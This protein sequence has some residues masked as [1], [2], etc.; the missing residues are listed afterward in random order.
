[1]SKARGSVS[2]FLSLIL[3][4]CLLFGGLLCDLARMSAAKRAAEGAADLAL[5]AVMS[6][7]DRILFER[8][9]LFAAPGVGFS[10]SEKGAD[11][12]DKTVSPEGIFDTGD[13]YARGIINRLLGSVTEAVNR[14]AGLIELE[15]TGYSV[16]AVPESCLGNPE[17]LERQIIDYMKYRGPLAAAATLSEKLG[18]VK[19]A[20]KSGKAASSKLK[21]ENK[22]SELQ[23]ASDAICASLDLYWGLLEISCFSPDS[24]G[25]EEKCSRAVSA[26]RS[27][28]EKAEI[29]GTASYVCGEIRRFLE[30]SGTDAA[31]DTNFFPAH[32][33]GL[34]K[35][36]EWKYLCGNYDF[37]SSTN[38]ASEY[39]IALT[40][41]GDNL[42]A[43][44]EAAAAVLNAE[45][46]ENTP[47]A[48]YAGRV[49]DSLYSI[50]LKAD[51][52]EGILLSSADSDLSEASRLFSEL[53]K[54]ADALSSLAGEIVASAQQFISVA[55]ELMP[56]LETWKADVEELSEG[57]IKTA[58][59]TQIKEQTLRIDADGARRL[60][61]VASGWKDAFDSASNTISAYSVYGVAVCGAST[62]DAE[63]MAKA[64]VRVFSSGAARISEAPETPDVPSRDE[65]LKR[66]TETAAF[67]SELYAGRSDAAL[68]SATDGLVGEIKNMLSD[69]TQTGAESGSDAPERIS[70]AGGECFRLINLYAG[71]AGILSDA[72]LPSASMDG[73]EEGIC[74]SAGS[75]A[76][77]SGT[78]LSSILSFLENAGEDA[79]VCGYLCGVFSCSGDER[80]DV[81]KITCTDRSGSVFFG[82]EIEY[83]IFGMDRADDNLALA[84]ASV[85]GIR[86]ALNLIYALTDPALGESSLA[87]ATAIAG[88]SGFGIP[89]VQ[90]LILVALA[91]AESV[92]DLVRL[93]KGNSVAVWKSGE[94]WKCSI[95][96]IIGS[97]A[98]AADGNGSDSGTVC[99]SFRDYM[100]ILLAAAYPLGKN[101]VLSRC[102]KLI[103][104]NMSALEPGFVITSAGT[105]FILDAEA[106]L[107]GTL[108]PL[109]SSEWNICISGDRGKVSCRRIAGY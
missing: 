79:L 109:S 21:Y 52:A 78:F 18:I 42:S 70:E 48:E 72:D 57:E 87:A 26:A 100:T 96:G 46:R 12:F 54:E 25:A 77:E 61:A 107:K 58:F 60:E 104:I 43:L 31:L 95:E 83:L 35:S 44:A 102:A 98:S 91:I 106:S 55:S 76:S 84:G 23:E 6:E 10:G 103:Q 33:D 93:M 17:V 82:K 64:S 81:N 105:L 69:K 59:L 97:V 45:G 99:M 19:E 68:K 39:L 40:G 32:A 74:D 16:R 51:E 5:S 85:F 80:D 8:Y 36:A 53:K 3:V 15:R 38:R 89:L 28:A 37:G 62:G 108:L 7:Y 11:Y 22:L 24:D 101:A 67:I 90:N 65:F 63:K 73:D 92:S 30:S 66:D 13:G 47:D 34:I 75:V 86:F 20:G 88:W 9:G 27:A 1:M 2:V 50:C 14:S 49:R 56:G 4:P 41:A 71:G 94:T 29:C